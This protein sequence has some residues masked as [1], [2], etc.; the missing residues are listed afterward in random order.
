MCIFIYIYIYVHICLYIYTY[1]YTY[2]YIY[3]CTY[4]HTYIYICIHVYTGGRSS[5]HGTQTHTCTRTA[6]ARQY[7]RSSTRP[8][9][10]HN[11]TVFY[12]LIRFFVGVIFLA[13]SNLY[14]DLLLHT[15]IQEV[16]LFLKCIFWHPRICTNLPLQI[17]LQ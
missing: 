15:T 3:K 1:I 14:P 9:P 10:P 4:T 2:T 12:F 16:S 11:P 13:P 6:L 8:P 7:P 5:S 17:T